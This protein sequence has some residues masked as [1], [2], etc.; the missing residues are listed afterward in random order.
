M[1]EDGPCYWH[2]PGYCSACGDKHLE[3]LVRIAIAWRDRQRTMGTR[4]LFIRDTPPPFTIT[5]ESEARNLPAVLRVEDHIGC[6]IF[7]I[8]RDGNDKRGS[9]YLAPHYDALELMP[10]FQVAA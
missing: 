4:T 10:L 9:R 2:S 7:G 3:R 6:V 5:L 8:N 1:T